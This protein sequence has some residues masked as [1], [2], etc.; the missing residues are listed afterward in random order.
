[1]AEKLLCIGGPKDGERVEV[2]DVETFGTSPQMWPPDYVPQSFDGWAV[3]GHRG[4][5]VIGRLLDGYAAFMKQW[6]RLGQMEALAEAER[7]EAAAMRRATIAACEQIT[8][9]ELAAPD[10]PGKFVKFRGSGA[11]C[12]CPMSVLSAEG[13]PRLRGAEKCAE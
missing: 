5:N 10:K 4:V 12:T 8:S 11:P 1:M 6:R 13:C 2:A 7:V 9:G 3:L